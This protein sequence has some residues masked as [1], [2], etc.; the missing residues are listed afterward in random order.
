MELLPSSGEYFLARVG[1]LEGAT[2][3]NV[4]FR[5]MVRPQGGLNTWI[6]TVNKSY[7]GSIKTIDV[8]LEDFVGK[9]V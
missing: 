3:G 7:D 5:I 2:A 6:A 4:K 9:K 1:F 8:S